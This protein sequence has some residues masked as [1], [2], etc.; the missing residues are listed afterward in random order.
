[1]RWLVLRMLPAVAVVA[2]ATAASAEDKV[3]NVYNWSDY[4]DKSVLDDFTKQTGIKVVY[5]VYDA[6]ETLEAKLYA[7][8]SGYD[9]VV[10]TDRNMQRMIAAGVLQKIDKS[11]IPNDSHQWKVISDRLA[12]LRSRQPVRRELHVG[13]DRARL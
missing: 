3:V 12:T 6:M 9:V 8:A 7:G 2:F 1:M 10:P 11:K 13:H 4:V 5:D